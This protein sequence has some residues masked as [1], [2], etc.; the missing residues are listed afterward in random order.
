MKKE[1]KDILAIA[2]ALLGLF[3]LTIIAGL[4]CL[5]ILELYLVSG[6]HPM[7]STGEHCLVADCAVYGFQDGTSYR[8]YRYAQ[9]TF[10]DHPF[11]RP[12]TTDDMAKIQSYVQ[13]YEGWVNSFEGSTLPDGQ[14]LYRSYR[15]D[16]T[17]LS[18]S[19]F[20]CLDTSGQDYPFEQYELYIFDTEGRTLYYMQ[21]NT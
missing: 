12:V 21:S 17:T 11:F 20:F 19:D 2:A 4:G 15:Y 10:E 6:P 18:E 14:A 13:N 9:A 5:L 7:D 1:I 8:E 16:I 3:V